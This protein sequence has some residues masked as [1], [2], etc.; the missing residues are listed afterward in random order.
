MVVKNP[1]PVRRPPPQWSVEA[2]ILPEGRR[3]RRDSGRVGQP[4]ATAVRGEEKGM[5]APEELD[6]Q[7]VPMLPWQKIG[8]SAFFF[9]LS[10]DC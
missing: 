3:R 6:Q 7:I 5:A 8:K 4:G 2:M 9:Y 1:E 10:A